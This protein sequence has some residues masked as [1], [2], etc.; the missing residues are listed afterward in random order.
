MFK[1][2]GCTLRTFTINISH[3]VIQLYSYAPHTRTDGC[4]TVLQRLL[5]C[6]PTW[7]RATRFVNATGDDVRTRC[8]AHGMTDGCTWVQR[9]CTLPPRASPSV[10]CQWSHAINPV[11]L[12]CPS[13]PSYA[14]WTR[15]VHAYAMYM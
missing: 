6:R 11:S 4:T 14:G 8:E 9:W 1:P 7:S 12:R 13:R 3:H 5:T 15:T 10:Y 2:A